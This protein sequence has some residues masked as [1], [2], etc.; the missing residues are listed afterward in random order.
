[1]TYHYVDNKVTHYGGAT[2]GADTA[3]STGAHEFSQV[4]IWVPIPL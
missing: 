3:Y 4:F 1:M 2:G